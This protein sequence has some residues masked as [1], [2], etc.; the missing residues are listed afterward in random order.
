MTAPVWMATPPEVHSALLSSGPGPGP[1]LASAGAWHSL[2]AEYAS[3]A[4]EL[5]GLLGGVQAGSWEGSSAESYVAAHVPYVAWLLQA[6][7]DS[8]G[9]A[10]QQESAAAA[11]TAALAT[12]PT[13]PELAA[14]HA[15]HAVLVATNFFGINTI[16]IALNEA[17]YLRMWIQAGTSMGTYHAAATA[18]VTAAPRTSPAPPITKAGAA[19]DPPSSPGD[20]FGLQGLL[21]DLFN[22]E[23]GHSLFEL[24]W[25]GNPFTSYS[26]GTS[27]S[28]ALGDIWTSF[29]EGLFVYDPQTLAFAHNPA[30]LMAVL[31]IAATQLIT[32]RIFDVVQ[33]VYNFP[34]LL[35]V[36]LPLAAAPLGAL[37]TFAG[38]AGLAPA[39][40]PAVL[41]APIP[42]AAELQPPP[43]AAIGSVA[44]S[45][46]P[47]PATAPVPHSAPAGP[48]ATPSPPP[49]ATAGTAAI[50]YPYLVAPP[51]VGF[52]SGMRTG[53][54]AS[55]PD[56]AAV[57]TAT[58]AGAAA[59]ARNRERR[60][61]RAMAKQLGRGYEY[62]DLEDDTGPDGSTVAGEH[63]AGS[64]TASGQGGGVLGLSGAGRTRGV[65]EAAGL[66][67]MAGDEF[68]GGPRSP[69]MPST[70]E[71]G[72]AGEQRGD[73]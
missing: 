40:P 60:R 2:S 48:P 71:A 33:L 25:P 53:A 20:P 63:G 39:V 5:S 56:T 68:G 12:M 10:A 55:A 22:F 7:A 31:L 28:Q 51:S 57:P 66:T 70:W 37:G 29:Y 14:N 52:G 13:L 24:I 62:M 72:G 58:A 36:A 73:G 4:D 49:A 9:I 17:D 34:Q 38:F 26:P 18:A 64:T 44:L 16:P 6:S 43:A 41:P 47:T 59:G 42:T 19:S 21:N 27:F 8:A 11:Y 50:G 65:T 67:T 45:P 61:Q 15:M 46:T 1:L 3:A 23:G 69:M 30:Q 54:Q 32:H 35:T